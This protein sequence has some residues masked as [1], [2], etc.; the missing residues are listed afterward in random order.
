VGVRRLLRRTTKF[1]N[2]FS[3]THP[4]QSFTHKYFSLHYPKSCFDPRIPSHRGDASR[5]SRTPGAAGI[6]GRSMISVR[7]ND[8]DTTV[9]SR[10]SGI[11]ELMPSLAKML[12]HHR[13][14]RGQ[15]SRSPGRARIDR[16]TIAQG[17]S[18]CPR[19]NLWY[20]PPA[21]FVAGGPWERPAPDL[22]CALDFSGGGEASNNSGETRRE[23]K[24]A[25]D[26]VMCVTG[27]WGR[28]DHL[29]THA[30]SVI[31]GN[32]RVTLSCDGGLWRTESC[33]NMCLTAAFVVGCGG[34]QPGDFVERR[35]P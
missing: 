12:A 1:T 5:S 13:R 8:S 18:G 29:P 30:S 34:M 24:D 14:R 28:P 9:K 26:I 23:T 11:P 25:C 6:S 27:P 35:H 16:N 22:P 7:T 2:I 21:F 20:L 33:R 31:R 3:A 10:G 15:D 4:V 19:P 32:Q 17:R